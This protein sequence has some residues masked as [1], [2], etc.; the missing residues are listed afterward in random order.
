[1]IS[2]IVNFL[3]SQGLEFIQGI[4]QE[5]TM[6]VF[7]IWLCC[8]SGNTNIW[9]KG[10]L[11]CQTN[12]SCPLCLSLPSSS[13]LQQKSGQ[14]NSSRRNVCKHISEDLGAWAQERGGEQGRE[15]GKGDKQIR[16]KVRI[17]REQDGK[18]IQSCRE[19]RKEIIG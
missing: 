13:S 6:A 5:K 1:M 4:F 3:L 15:W 9:H 14:K 12:S 19:K 18:K 17:T 16:Q 7:Y 10:T 8:H 2:D 11:S